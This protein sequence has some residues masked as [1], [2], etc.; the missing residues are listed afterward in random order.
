MAKAKAASQP[1]KNKPGSRRKKLALPQKHDLLMEAGYRCGNPRCPVILVVHILEDHHIVHVSD[2]GGNQP[3]NLLALCP[4]CHT[5]YHHGQINREAI[6]HWK[7]L[8]LALN[9]AF[10]R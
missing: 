5:L 2:G 4:N 10:D 8:L 6:R 9:H 7:G 3:S 1:K